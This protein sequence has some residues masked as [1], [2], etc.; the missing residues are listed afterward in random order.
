MKF[1][2]FVLVLFVGIQLQAQ[3][4][5]Y[6]IKGMVRDFHDGNAL[7]NATLS[8]NGYD[9]YALSDFDGNYTLNGLCAGNYTITVTHPECAVTTFN[10][11]VSQDTTRDF[12]LEHHTEELNA[13]TVKGQTI[14]Q[15]SV[16]SAASVLHT[17]VLENYSNASLGDALR[18]I[19][20][21]SSLN[22]GST[23]VKPVIQGLHSSRVL[24]INNGTRMEDQEW[25]V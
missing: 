18:E 4:C 20:G 24:I 7:A 23:V 2:N 15:G 19:P 16:S 9:I 14:N 10:V 11:T 1:F 6:T 17:K 5:N 13:V 21:V 22:T 12:K 3:Q 25:G 8:V